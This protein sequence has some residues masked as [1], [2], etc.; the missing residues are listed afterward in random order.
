MP[1]AGGAGGGGALGPREQEQQEQEQEQEQGEAGAA[2]PVAAPKPKAPKAKAGKAKA[3]AGALA[4]APLAGGGAIV[5][6][7]AKPS[8]G[9][10]P[11]LL[12]FGIAAGAGGGISTWRGS[13]LRWSQLKTT[14]QNRD[15]LV[16]YAIGIGKKVLIPWR[17]Q[18]QPQPVRPLLSLE[19]AHLPDTLAHRPRGL[20]L[21][22]EQE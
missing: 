1:E 2:G 9:G 3:G 16:R 21:H 7:G 18:W 15:M 10:A 5:V 11:A 19:R 8:P 20:C 14:E 22:L 17:Q 13:Q 4:T 12:G 6:R